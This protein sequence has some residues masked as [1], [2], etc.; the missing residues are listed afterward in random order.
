MLVGSITDIVATLSPLMVLW[1]PLFPLLQRNVL[2]PRA[3]MIQIL[4]HGLLVEP[5]HLIVAPDPRRKDSNGSFYL[6]PRRKTMKSMVHG[7]LMMMAIV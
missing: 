2:V 1:L 5:G 6:V 4:H 3:L 7:E